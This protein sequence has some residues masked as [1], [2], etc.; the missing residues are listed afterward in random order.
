[1]KASELNI[2]GAGPWEIRNHPNRG[3]I[4]QNGNIERYQI[5]VPFLLIIF[6]DEASLAGMPSQ[7]E[8]AQKHAETLRKI[9]FPNLSAYYLENSYGTFEFIFRLKTAILDKPRNDRAGLPEP[10]YDNGG[11]LINRNDFPPAKQYKGLCG[12]IVWDKDPGPGEV[13]HGHP[14]FRN[15]NATAERNYALAAI[16]AAS[17]ISYPWDDPGG[18]DEWLDFGLPSQDSQAI[19]LMASPSLSGGGNRKFIHYL[20]GG[21]IGEYHPEEESPIRFNNHILRKY[22]WSE[23]KWETF[24]HELGH[25][26]GAPD[27]YYINSVQGH[28]IDPTTGTSV[29]LMGWSNGAPH[30]DAFLKFRWDWLNPRVIT[31]GPWQKRINLSPVYEKPENSLLL[32]PD[33]SNHEDEFFIVEVR[34]NDG[35]AWHG[36]T[37]KYD[38][39]LAP[40]HRGVYVYHINS[41]NPNLSAPQ[42][43]LEGEPPGTVSLDAF[44]SGEI[45]HPPNSNFYDS[46]PSGLTIKIGG[47]HSN[48]AYFLVIEWVMNTGEGEFYKMLSNG[49]MQHQKIHFGWRSLWSHI[50]PG[51]FGGSGY[52][53][54]LFYDPTRGEAEFDTTDGKGGMRRLKSHYNWRR[55]WSHIIPGNFGGS[56]YTDLLFY[57]PTR[58]EAEFYT[59][60][61]KGGIRRLE[62]HRNWRRTWSHIIPGNYG[63]SGY[64]D[65]LFYDPTRGE[66]EFDTTDGKGG[67][68][69]LESH[70]SWRPTWYLIIGGDFGGSRYTDLLFFD[71]GTF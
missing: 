46:S 67:M 3:S 61:G 43:D 27:L 47:D 69:R 41:H 32:R 12:F 5:Q 31:P 66:A 64:T 48:G 38:K 21:R 63:G 18:I 60:D 24:A 8:A 14:W 71:R 34:G 55:T 50:I 13:P 4:V 15:Y 20:T 28:L 59:T 9:S 11:S 52:T 51:N 62:S 49:K 57:D 2:P 35:K 22:I 7:L 70:H 26:I 23:W 39:N 17:E 44:Q 68:R 65:L 19:F 6:N 16:R 53:D 10:Q 36:K 42:I 1:M 30:F 33:I 37:K 40:A 56:G 54:L 25:S 58:G 29:S 45:F